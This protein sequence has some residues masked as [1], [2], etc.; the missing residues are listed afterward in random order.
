MLHA[1]RGIGKTFISLS[2]AYAVASGGKLFDRW[3]APKPARVLFL[4]GEMPARTLQERL[5]SIVAGSNS[6][7]PD[8]DYLRILTPDM[9]DG[10]MPNLATREG[11]EA[12]AP[13]LEGVDLVIMDNLATLARHGRSNDEESWLPVQGWLLELR[14]LGLSAL[15][16]HHQGKGGDQRGTSAKEDI[17]DTII[18][19]DRPKDYR[20]EQGARFEIH[21]TKARGIC[22]E[23]AKPFEAQLA[24]MG[25]VLTWTT[26]DIEDAEL[27][28]LRTL[29]AEGYSYRDAAEEMGVSV[30]KVQRLKKKLESSDS[31]I[32]SSTDISSPIGGEAGQ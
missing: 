32:S 16:V 24:T 4:D 12:V 6:E 27:D 26:R 10:P 14:R 18:R 28:Q 30:G 15:M 13:F 9:Q 21:L 22:G 29:F 25:R 3:G 17:L 1:M 20:P 11:Q 19:L 5:A 23:D 2:V 8:N 7:V 31:R